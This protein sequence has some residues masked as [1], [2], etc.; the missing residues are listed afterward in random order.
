MVRIVQYYDTFAAI[1]LFPS[2][3]EAQCDIFIT[4]YYGSVRLITGYRNGA[5]RLEI[6]IA[7]HRDKGRK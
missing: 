1:E 2:P 3:T 5:E 7:R 4:L 6:K